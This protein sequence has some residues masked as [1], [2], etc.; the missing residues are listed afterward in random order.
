MA[1]L[2]DDIIVAKVEHTHGDSDDALP[3]VETSLEACE[4]YNKGN[5]KGFKNAGYFIM[6]DCIVCPEGTRDAVRELL[7]RDLRDMPQVTVGS[8]VSGTPK[9]P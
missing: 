9:K 2:Q 3:I 1:Q 5:L 7:V 6:Q 4:Y 8:G